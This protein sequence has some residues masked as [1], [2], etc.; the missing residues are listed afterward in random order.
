MNFN[1]HIAECR[2]GYGLSPIIAAPS[3]LTEM[4]DGLQEPDD[5]Q[6]QF[7]IPPFR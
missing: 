5:A 4:L 7:P 3:G 6:A 1:P 2:F